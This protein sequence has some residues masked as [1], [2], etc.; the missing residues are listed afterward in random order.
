MG[1]GLRGTSGGCVCWQER[2]SNGAEEGGN[3]ERDGT[4]ILLVL[5]IGSR[6]EC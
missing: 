1:R 5:T 3:A 4:Q 2:V 6:E